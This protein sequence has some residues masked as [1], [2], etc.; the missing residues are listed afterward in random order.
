M[1]KEAKLRGEDAGTVV[2]EQEQEQRRPQVQKGTRVHSLR[3]KAKP[4]SNN[5][6]SSQ[7]PSMNRIQEP[8]THQQQP[9]QENTYPAFSDSEDEDLTSATKENDPSLSPSPVKFAPPSPRKNTHGKRPLSVLTMP[10]DFDMDH[11]DHGNEVEAMTES[12]KNI[13][14]N[15]NDSGPQRKSPKLSILNKSTHPSRPGD[16]LTIFED[17]EPRRES[18]DGKENGSSSVQ[19]KPQSKNQHHNH[20][21][22]QSALSSTSNSKQT[23]T[24]ST[25]K[26]PVAKSQNVPSSATSSKRKPRIGIR[27][28]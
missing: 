15:E 4:S 10:L 26:K 11:H 28:L 23:A 19:G 27:R 3:M 24:T 18:L 22:N 1:V 17:P 8:S 16:E 9:T 2:E 14:A 5:E 12:E 20:P 13:A 7:R 25:S 6:S 21:H